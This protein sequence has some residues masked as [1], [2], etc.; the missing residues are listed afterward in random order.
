M[1]DALC[2]AFC[3]SL[4]VREVPCGLAISTGFLDPTGDRIGFY[5]IAT[6]DGVFRIEDNGV[7]LPM[8]EASGLDFSTGSRGEA[9]K[10]LQAEYGV[11]A[12]PIDRVFA[13]D[14]LAE[15][16]V[17]AAALRFVS[18]SLRVRDFALMTE[19][20][21]VSSF[22]DDVAKLLRQSIGDRAEVEESAPIAPALADFSA[23]FV[24]RAP[25]RPPVGVFLATGD[26][27][28]M[29]AVFVQMQALHETKTTCAVIAMVERGRSITGSVR[30]TA[31]NRLTALTEFRGDE[32]ASVQRIYHETI[33]PSAVIH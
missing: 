23:D 12:D 6:E 20:R 31:T 28:V 25:G 24:L 14:S 21:V 26:S 33:G 15:R 16:D 11:M 8:L 30:R 5:V 7:T 17:P 10:D 22:R 18:F 3:D 13:I 32:A 27:R 1:K 29:E 9:M 19:A 4:S 2:K